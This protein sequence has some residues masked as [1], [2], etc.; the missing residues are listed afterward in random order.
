MLASGGP[1]ALVIRRHGSLLSRWIALW[2]RPQCSVVVHSCDFVTGTGLNL[3]DWLR[4]YQGQVT[5][6]HDRSFVY[7]LVIWINLERKDK[8]SIRFC[9]TLFLFNCPFPSH[10]RIILAYRTSP[11]N[12]S[13]SQSTHPN[14]TNAL[15]PHNA[16]PQSGARS[17]PHLAWSGTN[18]TSSRDGI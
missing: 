9:I 16:D 18:S 5:N 14:D 13:L 1:L 15:S 3:F 11:E 2:V 6:S 10:N 4:P 17:S 7:L 8:I 12:V